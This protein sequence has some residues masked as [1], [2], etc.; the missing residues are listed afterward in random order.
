MR[1]LRNLMA[2]ALLTGALAGAGCYVET[3]SPEGV[4]VGNYGYEPMY[5]NGYMVYYDGGRPFYWAGGGQ[6]WIPATSPYYHSYIAHYRAYGPAYSRWYAGGGYRYR[7]F[8]GGTGYYGGHHNYVRT[9]RAPVR[10]H[11]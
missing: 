7:T 11:R 10:H 1:M 4:V 5:Y 9:Y 8:R 2:V 6:V 3:V